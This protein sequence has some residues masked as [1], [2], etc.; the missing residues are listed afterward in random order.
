MNKFFIASRI[1]IFSIIAGSLYM[2]GAEQIKNLDYKHFTPQQADDIW[3]TV[4]KLQ[5]TYYGY[6]SDEGIFT[7]DN[8]IFKVD[9]NRLIGLVSSDELLLAEVNIM[10]QALL[11]HDMVVFQKQKNK[12]VKFLQIGWAGRTVKRMGWFASIKQRFTQI[13]NSFYS[14]FYPQKSTVPNNSMIPSQPVQ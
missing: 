14:Y 11:R 1:V 2:R 5:N 7:K 4:E 9:I 13:M 3:A 10:L 12:V 8:S 6:L